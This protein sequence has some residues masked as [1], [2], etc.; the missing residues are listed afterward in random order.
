MSADSMERL[1]LRMERWRGFETLRTLSAPIAALKDNSRV[2]IPL[3]HHTA[4]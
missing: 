1:R 2:S 4:G 3:A